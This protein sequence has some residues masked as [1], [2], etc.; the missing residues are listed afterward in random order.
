MARASLAIPPPVP[1]WSASQRV[2]RRPYAGPMTEVAELAER[3][4][5]AALGLALANRAAKDAALQAMA[6][7]LDGDADRILAANDDDVAVPRAPAPSTPGRP[8]PAH[9]RARR[10]D[11]R[12]A[13]RPG[14]AARPGRRGRT[15]R[16]ARQR[17][18]AAPG[19]GALRGGRHHL[20]GPAERHG[21]RRRDLPEVRQRRLLRGS[22]SAAASN[23]AI[24]E[25]LRERRRAGG[26]A[27]RLRA[28][29]AGR[30]ARDRQGADAGPRAGRRPDPPRRSGADPVGGRE[31][32]GAGDR[33][34]CRQ[35]PRLRRRRGRPRHG[36]GHRPERQDRPHQRLQRRRVAAGAR[37]RRRSV[38]A[39]GRRA[40]S[41]RPA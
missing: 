27:G 19:A 39:E 15:G 23:A 12:G 28:A 13:A 40:R 24:V 4:R 21:R 18:G 34:R 2:G 10:G 41:R 26:T 9:P 14:P 6:D 25:V 16:H 33:D 37:R 30:L 31:L 38:R 32:D 1:G 35:L 3:S 29:G 22:C 11:G 8:A 36:A 20:R 5:V 17:A 7:A